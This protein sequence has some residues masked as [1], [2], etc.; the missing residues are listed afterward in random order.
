[1]RML[2]ALLGNPQAR[3]ETVLVAGTKGKGSMAAL[4]TSIL[5][6]AGHRVGRYTQPHLYS[7][8]ERT[9]A[10]G[11]YISED[12]VVD[13]LESM[14]SALALVQRHAREIG[15]LTTFDVGTALSLLHFARASVELA[16]VEAG[17]GGAG[18]ATN[19]LEPILCLIGPVGVDHVATLGATLGA[20]AH[21]KA[22]VAR[23]GI[24]VVVSHQEPEA[25]SSIR[26]VAHHVGA[27]L[28]ELGRD[29]AWHGEDACASQLCVS[30]PDGLSP[31]LRPPLV[32]PCQRDNAAMAIAAAQLLRWR[33]YRVLPEAIGN[34]L[35][36]VHWP[37]R[38]QTVV[39]EPLTVVDGAHNSPAA[40]ALAATIRECLPGRRAAL[41][42]GMSTEKDA[43]GFIAEL[44]PLADRVVATRARHPRSCDPVGLAETARAAGIEAEV[45]LSPADAMARAWAMQPADGV[46]LVTGSLFLVG[47]VLELLLPWSRSEAQAP[48]RKSESGPLTRDQRFKTRDFVYG[49]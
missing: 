30:G 7:Y 45:A 21:E 42:L 18:D 33:G 8:R 31:G 11:R 44:A 46:T 4:L 32:G 35:A 16:V 5:E 10:A 36:N 15:P 22:G 48:G 23:S 41:V 49:A 38:F 9:W 25:M 19:A 47:D 14:A 40:R 29:F 3:F 26:Q 6:A 20:I 37:G 2:L 24:D 1:M 34:G 17:V 27:R 43:A 13:A 12:E 28:C 39:G